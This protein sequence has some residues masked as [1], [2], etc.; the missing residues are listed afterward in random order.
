MSQYLQI[1]PTHPQKRLVSRAVAIARS[2]GVII[3]PT[4]SCYAL[5]C[6][7]GNKSAM[8]RIRR[9]RRVD[10]H[11]NFTLVC[12]N[13]A[14]IAGYAKMDNLAYR[15]VRTHTPGP[16]TFIL[17]ASREVPRRLQ[18]RKKKQLGYESPIIRSP[19]CC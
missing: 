5:G 17:K 15:L 8:E 12:S 9:I 3:Y 14:E 13:L 2:G 16:Y 6:C 11:H 7:I 18:H 10:Q 1:H 19:K 4:D